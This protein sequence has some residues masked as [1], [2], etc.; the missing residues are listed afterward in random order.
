L[1]LDDEQE[2]IVQ[3]LR[4]RERWGAIGEDGTTRPI[5][6]EAGSYSRLYVG[7]G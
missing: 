7:C 6:T 1:R 2:M 5:T 3:T 4:P